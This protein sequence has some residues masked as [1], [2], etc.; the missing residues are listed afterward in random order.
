MLLDLQDLIL[1]RYYLTNP[2][3]IEKSLIEV[4]ELVQKLTAAIKR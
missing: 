2:Q 3:A 4:P 1:L